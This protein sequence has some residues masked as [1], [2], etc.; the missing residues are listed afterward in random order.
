M[1]NNT[2]RAGIAIIT[3]LVGMA[4]AVS[5]QLRV[6]GKRAWSYGVYNIGYRLLSVQLKCGDLAVSSVPFVLK[7]A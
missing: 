1:I 6:R 5:V 3:V 7:N 4:A 2:Y